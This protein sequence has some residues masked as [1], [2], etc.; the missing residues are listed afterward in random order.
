MHLESPPTHSTSLDH[1]PNPSL[2]ALVSEC[3]FGSPRREALSALRTARPDQW[4]YTKDPIQQIRVQDEL[5]RD[6][7]FQYSGDKP[8]NGAPTLQALHL[9]SERGALHLDGT[10]ELAQRLTRFAA[11]AFAALLHNEAKAC[12]QQLKEF[13]AGTLEAPSN[14]EK[15]ESHYSVGQD[16]FNHRHDAFATIELPSGE[17]RIH[18]HK[19]QFHLSMEERIAKHEFLRRH[20]PQIRIFSAGGFPN[21]MYMSSALP[22]VPSFPSPY[23]VEEWI[24]AEL[25]QQK[26][27]MIAGCLGVTPLK[28]RFSNLDTLFSSPKDDLLFT[29]VRLAEKAEKNS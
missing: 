3:I 26:L 21:P 20:V 27:D 4:H 14:Y 10:C 9:T 15:K 1:R 16:R 12:L 8:H 19:H 25:S 6:L 24:S 22:I 28:E 18:W 5:G 17:L 7:L 11:R 29:A 13:V 2:P 23:N